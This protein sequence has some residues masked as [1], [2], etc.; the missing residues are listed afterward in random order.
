MKKTDLDTLTTLA[1]LLAWWTSSSRATRASPRPERRQFAEVFHP[2]RRAR[3]RSIDSPSSAAPTGRQPN[4]PGSSPKG[5]PKGA[6]TIPR[7]TLRLLRRAL[8]N[9]SDTEPVWREHHTETAKGLGVDRATVVRSIRLLR[10]AGIFVPVSGLQGGKGSVAAYEVRR[11]RGKEA[12]RHG[13]VVCEAQQQPKLAQSNGLHEP[14]QGASPAGEKLPR[15]LVDFSQKAIP[16]ESPCVPR[17][18][19]S[20]PALPSV[21]APVSAPLGAPPR[22]DWPPREVHLHP[23]RWELTGPWEYTAFGANFEVETVRIVTR[24]DGSL[25]WERVRGS[26]FVSAEGLVQVLVRV[27][28]GERIREATPEGKGRYI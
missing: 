14:V 21:S 28:R 3:K 20:A 12:L 19:V 15:S 22:K 1:E 25:G 10:T 4:P 9:T 23:G 11:A 5:R 8:K 2:Q 24:K 7:N 18:P 16:P 6:L 17:A 26:K 13:W 27:A